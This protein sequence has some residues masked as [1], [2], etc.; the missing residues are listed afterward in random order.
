MSASIWALIAMSSSR[1][2]EIRRARKTARHRP[3][4][5]SNGLNRAVDRACCVIG[6]E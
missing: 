4:T 6:E 3:A 5:S 1:S 2:R